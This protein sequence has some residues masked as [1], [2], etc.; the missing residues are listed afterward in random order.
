MQIINGGQTTVTIYQSLYNTLKSQ[1]DKMRNTLKHLW[2]PVKIVVPD[3]NLSDVERRNLRDRIS[4][5]ANSQTA[6]KTSDLSANE[7]F[8]LEFAK[9]VQE[10]KTPQ[11]DF[12]FYDRARRLYQTELSMK[13]YSEKS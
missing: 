1:R 6:V 5:A 9:I 3:E 12:W 2:V 11:N 10:L 8:Q 13:K 4:R 7:P